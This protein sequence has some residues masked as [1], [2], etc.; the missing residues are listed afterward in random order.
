MSGSLSG[1]K[2]ALPSRVM[3]V[4]MAVFWSLPALAVGAVFV[5]VMVTVSLCELS[6]SL[7][8]SLRV[9]VPATLPTLKI[10][11]ATLVLLKVAV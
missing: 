8:V 2:L 10:G 3:S 1:S 9:Y 5:A 6:P 7:T 4:F 11:L